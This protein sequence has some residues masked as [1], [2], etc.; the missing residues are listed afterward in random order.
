MRVSSTWLREYCDPGLAVEQ[1]AERIAMRTTEV[2]RIGHVGTPSTERF[3]VGRVLEVAPHPNADRLTVCAV[4]TGAGARTIVCGAPNVAAGQTV[5]V[6]LPGA[7]LPGGTE[8]GRAELRGVTSDGMI[9]SE[10][11]LEIGEDADGIAV[12]EDGALPGTPLSE[13]VAISDPVL[14]LEVNSNRV[15]CLGMYGVAREVHAIT[16]APLEPAPWE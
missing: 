5:P 16:A 11:E 10:A 12:L 1:L 9:L 7:V 2:E 14:E 4:D 13:V 3:V 6:A 15:D 8:L